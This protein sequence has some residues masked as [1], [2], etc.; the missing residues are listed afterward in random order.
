MKKSFLILGLLALFAIS[1][2]ATLTVEQTTSPEYLDAHGH[3]DAAIE[4]I[5][6]SKAQ[7][8][9]EFVQSDFEKTEDQQQNKFIKISRK[10]LEYIDPALDNGWFLNKHDITPATTP[11]D[12]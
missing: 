2:H 10:F 11:E 4:A 5:E 1:A 7:I 9:G 3:S 12:L 6:R 8:N